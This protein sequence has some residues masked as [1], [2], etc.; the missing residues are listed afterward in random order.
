MVNVVRAY[1]VAKINKRTKEVEPS[2]HGEVT[3][4]L[5]L[6]LSELAS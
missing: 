6:H 4:G 2:G 5:E 1:E 3:R